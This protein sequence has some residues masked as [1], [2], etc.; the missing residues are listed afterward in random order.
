[1]WLGLG[2]QLQRASG[3]AEAELEGDG[4]QA[5]AGASDSQSSR[6]A[7]ATVAS[8]GGNFKL[9]PDAASRLSMLWQDCS[10]CLFMAV[11]FYQ[12]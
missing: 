5:A 2:K 3:V 9:P 10:R 6:W 8:D 12:S 7:D 11:S 4:S 1:M